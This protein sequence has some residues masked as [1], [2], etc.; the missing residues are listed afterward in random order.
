MSTELYRKYIDIINENSVQQEQLNEG[1]VDKMKGFVPKLINMLGP[2]A[3][4]LANK[5]K[6]ITGGDFSLTADNAKKIVQGM[7]ASNVDEG[8]AG[9][10]QG[11]LI[12]ALYSL[13][14]LGSGATAVAAAGQS[15]WVS[16]AAFGIAI[17]L[18]MFANTFFSSQK[19]MVGAMGKHGNKG[20]STEKGPEIN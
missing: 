8:I 4:A 12:Q 20:L 17:L 18:L 2:D 6:E 11:K 14:I 7:K 9:N 10:W 19:G 5:V 1:L 13:G 3:Q 15:P 16:P